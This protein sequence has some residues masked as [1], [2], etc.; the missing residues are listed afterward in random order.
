VALV[1]V[2]D[3]DDLGA[4]DARAASISSVPRIP[5]PTKPSLT[6]LRE[7]PAALLICA[8]A[9]AAVPTAVA[10][11][12][13]RTSEKLPA[14]IERCADIDYLPGTQIPTCARRHARTQEPVIKAPCDSDGARSLWAHATRHG[15]RVSTAELSPDRPVLSPM[16]GDKSSP[17][18]L[19][20]W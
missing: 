19:D 8:P 20:R 16:K 6:G 11:R 12:G 17:I 18:W 5:T 3:G 10:R 13:A 9:L 15:K 7:S 14:F 4:G 1:A 2:R